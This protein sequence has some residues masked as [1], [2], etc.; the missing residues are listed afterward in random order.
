MT[1]RNEYGEADGEKLT[2]GETVE[3][4]AHPAHGGSEHADEAAQQRAGGASPT[5]QQ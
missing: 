2:D 1:E 4:Y 3:R 5:P